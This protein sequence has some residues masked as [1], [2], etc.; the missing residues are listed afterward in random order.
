[1]KQYQI[2]NCA[3][4]SYQMAERLC[5]KEDGKSPKYCP[6]ATKNDL[7]NKTIQEYKQ[8]E[9]REFARLASIQEG[10]GYVDRELD[11]AFIK[12]IKPRIVEIIE[13]AKKM[14]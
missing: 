12:P 3:Q 4:C 11:Y 10:E 6:T 14:N 5:R 7:I 1:M 9:L 13:F 8:P 2:T